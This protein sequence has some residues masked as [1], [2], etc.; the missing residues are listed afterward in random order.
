MEN[1]NTFQGI[2]LFL[3][4]VLLFSLLGCAHYNRKENVLSVV[5]NE[6]ITR[7]DLQYSL[8]VEHRRQDLSSAGKL[9]ISQFVEKLID[10]RLI[11][12]EAYRLGIDDNP[13]V[14]NPLRSFITRES[15]MKLYNEEILQKISVTE[16]D[17]LLY[18]KKNYEKVFLEII[19][20]KSEKEALYILDQLKSGESFSRL[21]EHYPVD[22][23]KND[24][25]E[26][27]FVQRSMTPVIAQSVSSLNTGQHSEVIEL[28]NRFYI[29]KLLRR[30]EAPEEGLQD[31]RKGIDRTLRKERENA[32]SKEY[33]EV[34]REKASITIHDDILT[35]IL[36]S[37]DNAGRENLL[38]D[39]R[40]LAEVN[41]DSLPVGKFLSKIPSSRMESVEKLL[42]NWIDTKLVDSE[43]LSR[44]YEKEHGFG[45]K[46][47]RYKNELLKRVF[48]R[49]IIAPGVKFSDN[50][51][52]EYYEKNKENYLKPLYYKVQQ[53]TVTT[54][55]E[56]HEVLKSL[57]K[58][59][60]FSWMAKTK[61]IDSFAEVGG[62]R[63][64]VKEKDLP[65]VA[66][67]TIKSLS[68]GEISPVL[69]IDSKFVIIRLLEK[70]E[71]EAN[72]FDSVK[73]AIVKA[74]GSEQFQKLYTEYLDA[75]RKEAQ[76]TIYDD[77]VQDLKRV[78]KK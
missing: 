75:L 74:Y 17:I 8:T 69:E 6:P 33:I 61:S 55:D 56:A 16:K 35:S 43:A 45:N 47:S 34:L 30:E 67:T 41:G 60:Q 48:I 44:H 77:R 66:R 64:W 7:D 19:N 36:Q 22:F 65:D 70:T 52:R 38:K 32:L 18:Y 39:E 50:D 37:D 46:V 4:C 27:V 68:P 51:L 71:V 73:N 49:Q 26:I 11:I 24:S 1:K 13:G 53:I 62:A 9:D 2:K 72:D 58:G 14:K 57:Q 40:I 3:S 10:D 59:A 20:V 63:D 78:L 42:Q 12:Q 76:I 31:A 21:A 23:P 25:G 29:V 15:V 54:R 28:N 5:N